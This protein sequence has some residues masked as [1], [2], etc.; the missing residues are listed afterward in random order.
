[1]NRILTPLIALLALFLANGDAEGAALNTPSMSGPLS[2]NPDPFSIDGGPLG[3]IYITGV[4]SGLGFW[5][6]NDVPGDLDWRADLSN[7][8]LFVQKTDGLVQFFVDVGAY[9]QPSLGTPYMVAANAINET[10]GLVPQAYLKIAPNDNISV[11]A[12]KLPTQ[13]GNENSLTFQNVNVERGLLWN[14][15]PSFTR[16]VQ[17]NYS[18]GP[19]AIAVSWNDGYYS[20]RLNWI[21][22]VGTYALPGGI[23]TITFIG[24]AAIGHTGY[25]SFVTPKT[26]S[27]STIFDLAYTRTFGAWMIDPYIQFSNISQNAEL[28]F[29]HGTSTFG[30]AILVSYSITK[31]FFLAGRVEY[32]GTSGGRTTGTPNILYGPGSNAWSLTFTPTYQRGIFF[33]RGEASFV[34]AGDTTRGDAFGQNLDKTSQTRLM[35]ETGVLF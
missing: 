5:Q 10:F 8:Q 19:L 34:G 23:D 28:G 7:A 30:G 20:D 25:S 31:E 22:G 9:S 3:T 29:I 6:D 35:L 12:G 27:N 13:I 16:G 18:K 26:L 2:A 32:I 15:T 21:T 33:A 11:E 4:A 1:M 17:A 24:G 14:Q